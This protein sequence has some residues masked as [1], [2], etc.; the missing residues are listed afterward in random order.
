[1]AAG[2]NALE[3]LMYCR[4][5]VTGLLFVVFA[6]FPLI[7]SAAEKPPLSPDTA[8]PLTTTSHIAA[9]VEF[10]LPALASEI[11]KDIPKRLAIID[12]RVN[13]VHRRVLV[14]RVN[15]NCD[16]WGRVDRTTPVSLYGR[17]DRLY[18]SFSI[19]GVA[20]GQ[21]ANR[22]TARIQG[23]TEARAMV[24]VEA[25][26]ELRKDWSLDLNFSDSFHWSE[27]P[28]LH[29]LGREVDLVPYVEPNI[30]NQLARIRSRAERAA[31]RLGLRGKAAKVWA[32]AFAPSRLSDDPPIWLQLTPRTVAFSGAHAD[33]QVLSG[34]L[35]ISGTAAT[36]IGQQPAA[37]TPTELPALGDAV[38]A[39]GK[40]DIILP[41]RISYDVLKDKIGQA[42]AAMPASDTSMREVEVYP[43][44]GKLVIGL[45]FAKSGD[46]SADAGQW[47][48]LSGTPKVDTD[49]KLVGLGNLDL[50]APPDGGQ[51]AP[52][53]QDLLAQLK[54]A[55]SI[56]YGVAYQNLLN[57]VNQQLTQ[58]PEL[59]GGYRTEGHVEEA[60]LENVQL[61]A[62]GLVVALHATGDL[63]FLYRMYP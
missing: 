10:G 51:I 46:A 16:V 37:V 41:V 45:R 40:F 2:A 22:F 19:Y 11:E 34:S 26:P 31:L 43:S 59:T 53:T 56:D 39:P 57:A 58:R 52:A 15:A 12:E 55:V 20:E 35:E 3:Q 13:C 29:V 44:S 21:G 62:D 4:L 5:A 50:S 7:A 63:K 28:F 54:S 33:A 27:P 23:G 9:T 8:T 42:I 1:M 14:F 48:Y 49:G 32:Q 25:R 30:R 36:S 17:G 38:S 61:L 47:L 24:E 6:A 18:G 60:R